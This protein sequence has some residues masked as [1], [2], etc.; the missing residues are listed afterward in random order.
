MPLG[1]TSS[2]VISASCHPYPGD[3]RAF[4]FPVKWGTSSA[5]TP[6]RFLDRELITSLPTSRTNADILHGVQIIPD[7]PTAAIEE[8]AGSREQ[9]TN[10]VDAIYKAE[11]RTVL[12]SD[13][14][15]QSR[16]EVRHC[17]FTTAESIE[18]PVDDQQYKYD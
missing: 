5:E 6:S 7:I 14:V 4:L 18:L 10:P 17:C 12:A 2:A 1:A 9:P 13:N 3:S 11:D 8:S 16:S 15:I